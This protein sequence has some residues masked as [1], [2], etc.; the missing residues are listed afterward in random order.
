[1]KSL[2][3]YILSNK[4]YEELCELANWLQYKAVEERDAYWTFH[5]EAQNFLQK[6]EMFGPYDKEYYGD[7][8]FP[9]IVVKG[10]KMGGNVP[11]T[12]K[13]IE[14]EFPHDYPALLAKWKNALEENE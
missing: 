2:N 4:E 7:Y 14:R 8:F 10:D 13:D 6:A 12:S 11:W 1:M 5:I 3:S 9:Y